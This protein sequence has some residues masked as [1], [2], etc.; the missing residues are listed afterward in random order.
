MDWLK[1]VS[2]A[3]IAALALIAL[4]TRG[5][6]LRSSLW[7]ALAVCAE[8]ASLNLYDAGP[9]VSYHRYRAHGDV[10]VMEWSYAVLGVQLVLVAWGLRARIVWPLRELGPL[11]FLVALFFVFAFAAKITRPLDE[12][13]HE[14]VLATFIDLVALANLALAVSELPPN[15][16]ERFDSFWRAKIGDWNTEPNPTARID[17]WIVVVAI[18]SGVASALF[19]LFVYDNHPHV[20]DEVVYLLHARYLAH[21][22][23]ELPAPP[24]PAAFD[25]DLMTLDGAR[26][27]SPVNPGWPFVLALGELV[28]APWIVD[29]LLGAASVLLAYLFVREIASLAIARVAAVL[30]AVSPWFLYMNMSFMT[31]SLTLF[32]GL[33]AAWGV[34]RARRTNA[35]SFAWL[36]GAGVGMVALIRPLEGLV[37]ALM[38][39][40][41]AIGLGG[42]RM[43]FASIAGLV[44]G[45]IAVA[46]LV[47]P[48][49]AHFTGSPTKFPI[50]EYVDRVYGP[51]KND[52]GFGANRGLGWGLDAFPGHTP[53]EALL[54][55]QTN[56]FAINA[57]LFG[58][59]AGSLVLVCWLFARFKFE[60]NDKLMIA[61]IAAIVVANSFYWFSGG[62]DFGARYW[63]LAIVPCILLVI[64]GWRSL[65]KSVAS[66]AR[67]RAL[68]VAATLLALVT[69]VPWR[70]IDKYKNYR[71]MSAG[72]RELAEQKHFGRS[73]VLIQ[74]PRFP[75]YES[76]AIYNPLDL[77]ADAPIYAMA[78]GLDESTSL[79][80]ARPDW[81]GL[82][83]KS[84]TRLLEH[85]RDRPV[86]FV[87]RSSS[88]PSGFSV[89]GGDKLADEYLRK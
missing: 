16:L 79:S 59:G 33:L 51:G 35:S 17:R 57:E 28:H 78:L 9:V 73:L 69:F 85:Y 70:S 87:G 83:S 62:P 88:S 76:A 27:Y 63:Y 29:P 40:V 18:S 3:P 43:S 48:Y 44:L 37:L 52:L 72:I 55:A 22:M 71:G 50:N 30:L 80:A 14:F 56:F 31:H 77:D 81:P 89:S 11:R 2:F 21:G 60:R 32:C 68:V 26:W 64:S 23:L 67:I 42:K 54:N 53:Y 20:P 1:Y 4:G 5:G 46:S 75:D 10:A 61:F 12:S 13:L 47:F 74:G 8:Q 45:T 25:L 84:V 58:W 34:A 65:E 86:W 19:C 66:P 6:F 36:A 41:W 82:D 39:G 24:V 7:L 15:A 38:L 49:N